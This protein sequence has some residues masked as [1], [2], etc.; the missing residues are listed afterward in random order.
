MTE[1]CYTSE[2]TQ[3][4]RICKNKVIERDSSIS[5]QNKRRKKI[6][7]VWNESMIN[8]KRVKNAVCC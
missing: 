3:E 8:K 6:I 2:K 4:I 5:R 7:Q 1:I